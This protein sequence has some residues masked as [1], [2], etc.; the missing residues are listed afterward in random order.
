[1]IVLRSLPAVLSAGN[2]VIAAQ[3]RGGRRWE[4]HVGV[5]TRKCLL[6]FLSVHFV[7]SGVVSVTRSSVAVEVYTDVD[8][9]TLLR[10]GDALEGEPVLSDFTLSLREWIRNTKDIFV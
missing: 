9:S 6:F 10:E 5:R 2:A 4:A 3:A 7:V 8:N 1:M